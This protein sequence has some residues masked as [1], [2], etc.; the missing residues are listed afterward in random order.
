MIKNVS[1]SSC[2]V[3]AILVRLR[4]KLNIFDIFSKNTQML[5]FMKIRPVGAELFRVDGRTDMTKLIFACRNFAN[6]L[7]NARRPSDN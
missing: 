5:N 3:P 4:L 7:S 1:Q 2:K 6:V